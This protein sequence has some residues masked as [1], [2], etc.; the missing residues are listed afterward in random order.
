MGGTVG[1]GFFTS[2]TQIKGLASAD[3]DF[4]TA[5]SRIGELEG[6]W[7]EWHVM[8]TATMA[9][10]TGAEIEGRSIQVAG[11]GATTGA[12]Q[13]NSTVVQTTNNNVRQQTATTVVY[14]T[15][16]RRR[17]RYEMPVSQYGDF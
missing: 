17:S 8:A 7:Y 5:T 2:G 4:D 6:F 14:A 12:L 16:Q 9:I 3:V 1:E 13:D 11:Q 15:S 10:A